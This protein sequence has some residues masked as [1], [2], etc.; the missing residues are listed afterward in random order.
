MKNICITGA[1][2][3]LGSK[4]IDVNHKNFKSVLALNRSISVK[5]KNI[6]YEKLNLTNKDSVLNILK[7]HEIDLVIH[8]A[9]DHSYN[10]NL[11]I[12]KSLIYACNYLKIKLVHISTIGVL[13]IKN[14][15]LNLNFNNFFDPY[16][17]TKRLVEKK[18]INSNLNYKII[19]PTIVYGSGGNWTKF[20]KK[21]I[22]AK[23]FSLPKRGLVEC[24]YIHV[25]DFSKKLMNIIV[26]N[27]S[28]KKIII[29]DKNSNWITLYKL[30]SEKKKLEPSSTKNK[31]HNNQIFNLIFCIW[32]N[33][34]FGIILNYLL[35]NYKSFTLKK[36]KS[37]SKKSLPI[38]HVSPIFM[39]RDIHSTPF[40]LKN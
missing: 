19:Y 7:S 26:D 10:Q 11:K 38:N 29:G 40:K 3:F 23:S 12:I 32:K 36:N 6:S 30:H 15:N 13:D 27:N 24:N 4:F 31:Y 5:K 33:T 17:Y 2:G 22:N 39:N 1:T 9:F 14:K 35:S 34:F 21:C 8:F 25:N 37:N 28:S 20:I 18:I 16:S